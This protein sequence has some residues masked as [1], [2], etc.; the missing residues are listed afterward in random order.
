MFVL[1]IIRNPRD[2]HWKVDRLLN[3]WS[4]GVGLASVRGSSLGLFGF[5]VEGLGFMG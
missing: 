5:I 1:V 2:W 4:L 3:Q